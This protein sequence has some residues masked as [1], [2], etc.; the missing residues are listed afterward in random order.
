MKNFATFKSLFCSKH[1]Y[2]YNKQETKED[3]IV[4][5]KIKGVNFYFA[6]ILLISFNFCIIF[7]VFLS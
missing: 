7:Q 5:V 2:K 3:D 6:D 1:L 4:Y